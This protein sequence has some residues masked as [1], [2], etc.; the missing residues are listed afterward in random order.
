[1]R[2]SCIR[3]VNNLAAQTSSP[4]RGTLRF[5]IPDIFATFS[6]DV[7]TT[8]L[9]DCLDIVLK[10]QY[11]TS[12]ILLLLSINIFLRLQLGGELCTN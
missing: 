7:L 1:M 11:Y 4:P 10:V 6:L 8:R 5:I 9:F 3:G 12:F 2:T